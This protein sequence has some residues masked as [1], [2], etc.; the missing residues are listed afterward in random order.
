MSDYICITDINHDGRTYKAGSSFP[1]DSG[2]DFE[3]LREC[4]ALKLA[5]EANLPPTREEQ[6]HA[7]LVA[8][9]KEIGDLKATIAKLEGHIT[10]LESQKSPDP[11]LPE[12]ED[13][14]LSPTEEG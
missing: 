10:Y 3:H 1:F 6:Q 9:H 12:E 2:P 8:A 5:S 13:E 7:D 4:G 11:F 14:T